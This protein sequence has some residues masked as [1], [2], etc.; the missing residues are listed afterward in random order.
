MKYYVVE[1]TSEEIFNASSK[2]RVDVEHILKNNG[3]KKIYVKSK[4][5]LKIQ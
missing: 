2:A 1:G 5:L 3:Y 4:M